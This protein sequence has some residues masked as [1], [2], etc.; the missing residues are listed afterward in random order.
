V[1]FDILERRNPDLYGGRPLSE[2]E[3]QIEAWAHAAGLEPLFF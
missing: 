1:N 2:L 3:H